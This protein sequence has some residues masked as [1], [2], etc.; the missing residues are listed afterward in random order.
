[1]AMDLSR[2]QRRTDEYFTIMT[3]TGADV[4]P[5]MYHDDSTSAFPRK[6][7]SQGSVPFTSVQER[8]LNPNNT[9]S[10]ITPGPGAYVSQH[11]VASNAVEPI[12]G[13]TST[14]SGTSMRS[15]VARLGPVA[16]G[17]T[18]F[19]TS[20][21]V[22]N[23]GPGSYQNKTEWDPAPKKDVVGGLRPIAEAVVGGEKT[24]PSIPST[25]APPGQPA[26]EEGF[27]VGGARSRHKG[28][29]TDS[30]GPGGYDH[31][32]GVA[33]EQLSRIG[34]NI[35]RGAEQTRK[36]WEPSPEIDN[37][38]RDRSVPGPGYYLGRE[39]FGSDLESGKGLQLGS[40]F[41]SKTA[42][43]HQ[44]KVNT[45]RVNPGP[46]QY[47]VKGELEKSMKQSRERG[48]QLDMRFNSSSERVG[49]SRDVTQPYKD[50][51]NARNVPGPG[52]YGEP[53]PSAIATPR[54]KEWEKEKLTNNGVR[55]LHGVHHPAIQ[56]ALQD[57]QAPLQAFSTSENRPCLKHTEPKTPAPSQYTIDTA[58]GYSMGTALREKGKV[59]RKGIFGSCADRFA[60]SPLNPHTETSTA[61]W[62]TPSNT[63]EEA[64]NTRSPMQSRSK[65]FEHNAGA[66]EAHV[67]A[68]GVQET[69][70]PLSYNTT[71]EPNYRSPF[72][73]PRRDHFSFGSSNNRFTGP[74]A[75]FGK[76]APVSVD[77]G[78]YE[79]NLDSV[80]E[81][82]RGGARHQSARPAPKVGSNPQAVGPGSFGDP[83]NDDN[84]TLIKKT[85][86]VSH[87]DPAKMSQSARA[88]MNRRR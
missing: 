87:Q 3:Q 16:P 9:T 70:G 14:I 49:W 28:D 29:H 86:N 36:L 82:V 44:Q 11:A 66:K 68:V 48:I 60:G 25:R 83:M 57:Q 41:A 58:R 43:P 79:P 81:R 30:V 17:S 32:Q 12:F 34:P 35:G 85:F 19:T 67:K 26:R 8:V 10:G 88:S 75:N 62:K 22:K 72:R 13:E 61:A 21:I 64:L 39:K 59:G 5:G 63:V 15:N 24:A 37:N 4:S 80:K 40:H 47:D 2:N 33:F 18:I 78:H 65:R 76:I 42:L 6:G 54:K 84:S 27:D 51:Y 71:E 20:T 31:Q 77:P 7:N 74:E 45:E 69:P 23:P 1:M 56:M 53:K 38:Y 50:P 52:F 46:G 73:Q 55:K